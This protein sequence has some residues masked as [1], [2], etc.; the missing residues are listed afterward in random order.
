MRYRRLLGL[1]WV[2]LGSRLDFIRRRLTFRRTLT[3][4]ERAAWLHYWS[5]D[6]LRRWGIRHAHLGD[7]PG[8][9]MIV[10]NH[11]SYLDVLLFGAI[12]PC[13]FI[14]KSDLRRW[15]F[16]GALAKA[17]G[18]VFVNRRTGIGVRRTNRQIEEILRQGM[19]VVLFPEGTSS[20]GSAVL[21]F[22]SALF[23]PAVRLAAKITP[24]HVSYD[25]DSGSVAQDICYW[26]DMNFGLHL[27]KLLS[28]EGISGRVQIGQPLELPRDRKHAATL[29]REA[30]RCLSSD[31]SKRQVALPEGRS[32]APVACT[33]V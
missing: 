11:L 7:F 4:T 26:G 2:I 21:P 13:V 25:L 9:G 31:A 20:D 28:K 10:S 27:L 32:S 24:A 22:K 29:A 12:A 1:C 23:E 3:I 6:L 14:A 15:P 30:V 17:G 5:R 33:R 16:F 18:A 8:G 19:V